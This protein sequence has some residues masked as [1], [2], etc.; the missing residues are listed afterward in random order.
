MGS[1]G[2]LEVEIEVKAS[3]DKFWECIR[4]STNLFPK[5]LS[6]DYKS[7]DVLE[8][9]PLVKVDKERIDAVDEANKAV[10]YSVIE[11]DLVKYYKN[12]KAFLAVTPKGEGSLV[13]WACE[14]EKASEDVPNPDLVKDFAIKN[15]LEVDSYINTGKA[16]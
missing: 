1:S 7:I 9:S 10:S 13:K 4:D 16:F 3:A 6:H 15:F 11:G 2:K 8:G 12:F 14:F 5:A